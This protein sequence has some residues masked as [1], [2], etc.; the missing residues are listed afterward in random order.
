MQALFDEPLN[1]HFEEL[2]SQPEE[3]I[4]GEFEKLKKKIEKKMK[5]LKKK[6]FLWQLWPGV[7]RAKTVG[8]R[9]LIQ[10]VATRQVESTQRVLFR[11]KNDL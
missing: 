8:L 10:T 11:N 9:V 2:V 6:M 7:V 4:S 1:K 3:D 5:N